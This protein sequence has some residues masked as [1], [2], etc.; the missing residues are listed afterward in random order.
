MSIET[1]FDPPSNML[2]S[3]PSAEMLERAEAYSRTE[4]VSFQEWMTE[5]FA[6]RT[7]R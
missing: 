5:I 7:E 1:I 6:R 3:S 2:L 4:S